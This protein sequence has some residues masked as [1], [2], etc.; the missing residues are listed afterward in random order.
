MKNLEIVDGEEFEV[1]S[2]SPRCYKCKF[3]QKIVVPELKRVSLSCRHPKGPGNP[4]HCIYF[5]HL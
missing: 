3:K 1:V 4:V 5:R 2:C